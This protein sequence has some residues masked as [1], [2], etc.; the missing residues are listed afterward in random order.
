MRRSK[1]NP[2]KYTRGYRRI[3]QRRMTE[4]DDDEEEEMERLRGV[5]ATTAEQMQ[6]AR[7]DTAV[8]TPAELND[9]ILELNDE[10]VYGEDEADVILPGH[11]PKKSKQAPRV[12]LTDEELRQA[13]RLHKKTQRKLQQLEERATRKRERAD[14]YA[15]LEASAV[16]PQ[17][18]LLL[19]SSSALGQKRTKR[20]ELQRLLQKERAGLELTEEERGV[21]YADRPEEPEPASFNETMPSAPAKVESS[22]NTARKKRK[23]KE[24]Q[25]DSDQKTD[26]SIQ[27]TQSSK[28]DSG[29][30]PVEP[31]ETNAK[32]PS[33]NAAPATS[34][35][36]S[37]FAAQ[38][39]ASLT[40]LKTMSTADGEK[41]V[42]EKRRAE[43]E[44]ERL[45]VEKHKPAKRYVP[46]EPA[47]LQTAATLGLK[48][49]PQ[50]VS[51]CKVMEI[52]RPPEIQACRYDLPV[53]AM[54]FE[55]MD[56]IRNNDVT[57]ICGE[58]GSGKSTQIPQFIY[59]SGMTLLPEHVAAG[60]D[61]FLIGITQPRRVAAVSTAKR[62]CY[63]MG[64]GNGQTI[65]NKGKGGSLVAYQT[66]YERAGLGD[67]THIKF[68]TDGI[69]LQEI[70][71]D[72]LLRK[73][74]VIVLDEAHERNLNTDVLIGLLSVAIPLRSQA[75]KEGSWVPLKLVI[76]SAT[77]R[78][79]DFTANDK[80]FA[81]LAPPAVVTIPGRTYPVTIH[82][83]KVTELDNYGRCLVRLSM[84]HGALSSLTY[85]SLQRT[86]HSRRFARFTK[87]CRKVAY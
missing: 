79:E 4:H 24:A 13:S 65:P 56:A 66:R 41:A 39:M 74:S 54:E 8:E 86:L 19:Q 57:I 50:L 37:S 35:A 20:Q 69:L 73:Y 36:A 25:G 26:E 58:T 49:Q 1:S 82:H 27:S 68:M 47:K 77:L 44:R 6:S 31:E 2:A 64:Q 67:K 62:V 30:L 17:Q 87:S 60:P 15:R 38:M 48:Q 59:E 61:H 11:R 40:Q 5:L 29:V 32:A 78:V 76:M 33:V 12:H 70:Q 18:R 3:S 52:T 34:A 83:S 14:V 16:N 45:E 9:S 80:L 46:S 7:A 28:V 75:A 84:V 71:S 51:T 72:L 23:R 81:S 63:E 21:L 10:P 43:E 55:V 53:S 42:E 22:P 85:I